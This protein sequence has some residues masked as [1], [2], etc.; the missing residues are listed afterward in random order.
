LKN[1]LSKVFDV[2]L[3]I[4]TNSSINKN[5]LMKNLIVDICVLAN[6]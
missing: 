3:K 5:I 6:S 4:K 2:E 1:I